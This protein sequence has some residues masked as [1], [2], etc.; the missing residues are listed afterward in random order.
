MAVSD[1]TTPSP[2]VL[3]CLE[4]LHGKVSARATAL[5]VAMGSGRHSL[6]LAQSGYQVF[7]VDRDFDRTR[8]ARATL[9][10]HG[11]TARVWVADLETTQLPDAYFD[12]VVCTRYLQRAFWDRLARAVVPGGFV[13]YETFTV[14]QARYDWGPRSPDH[15]LAPGELR[16]AFPGWDVWAF[17]ERESPAAEAS[18]FARRPTSD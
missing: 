16:T 8:R 6:I 15:L 18:L 2:F 11:S 12:V 7:G 4:R 13:V 17:D 3:S 9:R 5:D 14:G 10:K 1:S